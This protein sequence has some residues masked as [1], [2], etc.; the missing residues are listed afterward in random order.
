MCV[1]E[2]MASAYWEIFVNGKPIPPHP[3]TLTYVGV[4]TSSFPNSISQIQFS[5]HDVIATLI[6]H[7]QILLIKTQKYS[8]RTPKKR[9]FRI[10]VKYTRWKKMSLNENRNENK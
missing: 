7:Y 10:N 2:V 6:T 8:Q 5:P 1:N 4:P 3:P 9:R